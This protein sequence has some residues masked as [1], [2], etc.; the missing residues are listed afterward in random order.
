MNNKEI[1][2]IMQQ[3]Y[4]SAWRKS[5]VLIAEEITLLPPAPA[6]VAA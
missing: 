1:K 6:R 4:N 3:R 5:F 2:N